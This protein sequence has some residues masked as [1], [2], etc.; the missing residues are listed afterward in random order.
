M[1]SAPLDKEVVVKHHDGTLAR[2]Q[3]RAQAT[4]PFSIPPPITNALDT[5]SGL[6]NASKSTADFTLRHS[7]IS[8]A[9]AIG[10]SLAI[11]IVNPLSVVRPHAQDIQSAKQ[12][13]L[14]SH[15]SMIQVLCQHSYLAH[16]D[17]I[18]EHLKHVIQLQ[19]HNMLF[20]DPP[21]INM[22]IFGS[23]IAGINSLGWTL[24]Q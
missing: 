7:L 5:A 14:L 13:L 9:L 2:L 17:R 16:N 10:R 1:T 20:N 21:Y 6:L 3:V 22:M 18:H 4:N 11:E 12:I 15:A 8:K 23:I 19:G 24:P